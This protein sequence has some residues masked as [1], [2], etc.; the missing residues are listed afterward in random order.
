MAIKSIELEE[1]NNK[2]NVYFLQ[3]AYDKMRLYVDLCSEEI[4]W[5]G[6]VKKLSNNKGFLVEDVFLVKQ[7]VHSTTTELSPEAINEY[8]TGLDEQGQ[9]KFLNECR[10]WG[11]SHVNMSTG[12]SGQD[13]TQGKELSQ[14]CE[15]YY[16]RLIT[17]KRDEYNL[18]I[19]DKANGLKITSDSIMI[20]NPELIEL[21]TQIA[22]EIKEKVK[23]KK[24]SAPQVYGSYL[25]KWNKTEEKEKE[26][27]SISYLKNKEIKVGKFDIDSV[28][29]FEDYNLP[30][31]NRVSI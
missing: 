31:L 18:T 28:F 22:Q 12:P 13:D 17:N 8:F 19:Y 2:Y 5:L 26:Q 9:V 29:D 6:Y 15:D 4:G 14:D 1:K 30:I 7:E 10:I 3:R 23:E 21:R 24:I 20:Y 25:N 11:H 16:I 27:K